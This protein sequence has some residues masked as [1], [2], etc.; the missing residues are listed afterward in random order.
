M[1]LK[2]KIAK[3]VSEEY[4]TDLLCQFIR[5]PSANPPGSSVEITR[6]IQEEMEDIGID[7]IK[8]YEKVE[9]KQNIV[10]KMGNGNGPTFV[11][12]AHSDV[13]PIRER[14]KWRMDPMAG[15]VKDEKVW[16]RGAADTKSGLT[17][18]L[19]AARAIAS[20]GI[21]LKGNL[22]I[23]SFADGEQGDIDG[24][25][26]MAEDGLLSGDFVVSCEP[27]GYQ[28]VNEFMGRVW[29][30]V[31][32]EGKAVHA[33]VPHK[34]INAIDKMNKIITAINKKKLTYKPHPTMGESTT[35]FTTI[36]GGNVHNATAGHCE[37]TFDTR[38]VPGQTVKGVLAEY[39]QLLDDL[40]AED[41]ELDAS[42]SIHLTGREPLKM[43]EADDERVKL[44]E[45][46]FKGIDGNSANFMGGI[47][48]PG[49]LKHFADQGIPGFSF[50]PGYILNAHLPNEYVETYRLSNVAMMYAL[51]AAK[52]CGV[53]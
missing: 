45:D 11:L 40:M 25:K 8:I 50:G 20:S 5:I 52:Y 39:Q 28:I 30:K 48:S 15:I 16:G 32:V 10:G 22:V 33:S 35:T 17:S 9:G 27:T 2:E 14:A 26:Y 23:I 24:A 7:D 51:F 37:A 31:T 19:G 1:G 49:A 4:L 38:L 29:L 41:N 43:I 18:M 47:E 3:N 44:F 36:Q 46:C 34:G 12:Y 42:I 53:K 21:E 13:V 6:R